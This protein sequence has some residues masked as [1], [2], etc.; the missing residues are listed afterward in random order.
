LNV[1]VLSLGQIDGFSPQPVVVNV[2]AV[3]AFFLFM[4]IDW[5]L[6]ISVTSA[7]DT[8]LLVVLD[9]VPVT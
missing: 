9:K 1:L 7:I 2:E 3:H 5:P 8:A 4:T 6:S